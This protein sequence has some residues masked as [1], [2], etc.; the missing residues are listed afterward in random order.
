MTN[1]FG[2]DEMVKET[3]TAKTTLFCANICAGFMVNQLVRKATGKHVNC[4][5]TFDLATMAFF[6]NTDGDTTGK[7]WDAFADD[8]KGK[9]KP[10]PVVEAT[11]T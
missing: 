10:L 4:D 5:F 1:M 7:V 11:T 3:C 2:D 6:T 8:G 9:Y